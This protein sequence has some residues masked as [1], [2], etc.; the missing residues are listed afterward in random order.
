MGL[1]LD[2]ENVSNEINI[3]EVNEQKKIREK[4]TCNAVIPINFIKNCIDTLS[5]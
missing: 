1:Q 3:D 2:D 5:I 4:K